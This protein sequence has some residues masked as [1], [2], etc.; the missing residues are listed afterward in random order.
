LQHDSAQTKGK[1]KKGLKIDREKLILHHDLD[2]VVKKKPKKSF[3][4]S[5]LYVRTFL[6]LF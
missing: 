2:L 4:P 1:G 6:D 3:G 5:K